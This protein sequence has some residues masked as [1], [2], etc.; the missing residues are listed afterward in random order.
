MSRLA[1]QPWWKGLPPRERALLL[2]A[3]APHLAIHPVTISRWSVGWGLDPNQETQPA[4]TEGRGGI[5]A[6]AQAAGAARV[7]LK[8][9]GG[10]QTGGL[11]PSC[12]ASPAASPA[13]SPV[14]GPQP[15]PVATTHCAAWSLHSDSNIERGPDADGEAQEDRGPDSGADARKGRGLDLDA[16]PQKE[17]DP[18]SGANSRTARGTDSGFVPNVEHEAWFRQLGIRSPA[19]REAVYCCLPACRA[20]FGLAAAAPRPEHRGLFLAELLAA[21]DA[22]WRQAAA[23]AAGGGWGGVGPASGGGGGGWGG[24][25]GCGGGGRDGSWGEWG[26]AP[27]EAIAWL[28][29]ASCPRGGL[30]FELN[31][32]GNRCGRERGK[33]TWGGEDAGRLFQAARQYMVRGGGGVW[34]G[35]A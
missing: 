8:G 3:I 18:G 32:P 35:L 16:D 29:L 31:T 13:G 19:L 34:E 24:G 17:R 6:A 26:G 23:G 22:V 11:N 20:A 1:E 5:A 30:G 15:P 4:Q 14:L 9:E 27:T 2:G 21:V 10:E 7:G 33:N 12:A 25:G 28:L